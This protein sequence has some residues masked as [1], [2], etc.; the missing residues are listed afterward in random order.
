M[1]ESLLHEVGVETQ[2]SGIGFGHIAELARPSFEGRAF[3]SPVEP[4]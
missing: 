2:A 4:W 3:F 1:M